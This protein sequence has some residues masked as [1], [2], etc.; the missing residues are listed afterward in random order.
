MFEKEKYPANRNRLRFATTSLPG[1]HEPDF[2]VYLLINQL[3]T[4]FKHIRHQLDRPV[5]LR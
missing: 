1:K 5:T 4:I 3:K 2:E